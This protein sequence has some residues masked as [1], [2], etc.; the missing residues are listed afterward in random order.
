MY[1]VSMFMF[2]TYMRSI[3]SRFQA[4][5]SRI[6]KNRQEVLLK[7]RALREIINRVN[8][9]GLKPRVASL[10]GLVPLLSHASKE[11]R[12]N[13]NLAQKPNHHRFADLAAKQ[14]DELDATLVHLEIVAKD[15]H[16]T[17]GEAV[18]EF[19]DLQD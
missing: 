17:M 15:I 19:E 10:L 5:E 9:D 3:S 13:I 18:K 16:R 6:E 1:A 7:T 14:L 11:A 4:Y 2:R 12:L 8:H